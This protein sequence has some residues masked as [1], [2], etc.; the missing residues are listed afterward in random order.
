MISF[1]AKYAGDKEFMDETDFKQYWEEAGHR[2]RNAMSNS[3]LG[4]SENVFLEA[5]KSGNKKLTKSEF[6][7]W[8]RHSPEGERY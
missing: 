2:E 7:S 8:L 6:C 5:S 4:G 1:F 3:P